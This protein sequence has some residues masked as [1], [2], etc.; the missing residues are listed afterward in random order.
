MSTKPIQVDESPD[1]DKVWSYRIDRLRVR[2][3]RLL[4]LV[5]E[6]ES[7]G[8]AARILGVSQPAATGLLRELELVFDASLVRR[9][10][11]GS[12][13]TPAGRAALDH[14]TIVQSALA[15]AVRSARQPK[16]SLPL[17]LGCIQVAGVSGLAPA[18]DRLIKSHSFSRLNI[19][20]GRTR[21]LLR[22]LCAGKLDCVIG[23][24]DELQPDNPLL[25][26]LRIDPLWNGE[27]QL[28]VGCGHV[29]AKKRSVTV[30]DL[31]QHQWIIPPPGSRTYE[32]F[33]RLFMRQGVPPPT[34]AVECSAVHTALHI[35]S[36]TRLITLAP[37]TVVQRYV[38]LG[39]VKVIRGATFHLDRSP[40]SVV[41]RADS[42]S[43]PMMQE[44]RKA[45]LI[46]GEVRRRKP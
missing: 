30:A 7:L 15:R 8:S 9:E 37:D 44:L 43:F 42:N 10:I 32:T 29:L 1:D 21:D 4:S 2:H 5:A 39:I 16:A 31:A 27:M 20:E 23:W 36:A 28:A 18:L 12:Y 17:R 22:D 26:D 11:R 41:S 46:R 45:L 38:Q 35:A 3:L 33:R 34:V 40:V 24:I 14:L 13:L 6:H 25:R 19:R